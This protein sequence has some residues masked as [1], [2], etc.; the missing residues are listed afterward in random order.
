M[1]LSRQD[2]IQQR[3][4]EAFTIHHLQIEN[5][6]TKHQG[7][8]GDDGSGESHFLISIS[9]PELNDLNRVQK[10]RKVMHALGQD[11]TKEVHSISIKIINCNL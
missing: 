10:H 6:S 4:E 8:A 5:H 1:S 9:A 7:H 2:L 3:L 11:I